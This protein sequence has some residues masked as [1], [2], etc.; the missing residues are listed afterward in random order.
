VY[1]DDEHP[2]VAFQVRRGEVAGDGWQ[3]ARIYYY[4]AR[5]TGS[6]WE[7]RFI[8]HA[9]RPLYDRE[10]DYAG[11]ITIDP[12][13]PNVVYLSS[14]ALRPFD[15]STVDDVPLNPGD[16]YTLYRGVTGDAGRTFTWTELT[17]GDSVDNLRPHAIHSPEHATAV[18]WFRGR[19]T[20]YTDFDA[21]VM[22]SFESR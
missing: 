4:Y 11:G 8:A 2:V 6:A 14:N 20:T 19:Y 1:G 15:L 17:P 12:Q 21:A 13:D 18:V 5:W 16:R 3:D 10:Q 22:G 7:K 9:G